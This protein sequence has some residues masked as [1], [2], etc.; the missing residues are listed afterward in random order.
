MTNDEA[1]AVREFEF[2]LSEEAYNG[3]QEQLEFVAR[4]VHEEETV[5]YTIDSNGVCIPVSKKVK[6]TRDPK[7]VLQ[8][9]IIVDTLTGG[10][11]GVAKNPNLLGN[12]G[13]NQNLR[14][15]K[16]LPT[17]LDDSIVSNK[18]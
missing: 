3:V 14:R 11:L 4:G 9:L 5:S 2:E 7:L 1:I 16:M 6:I 10:R 15:K 12:T 17:I 18:S 8:S 13:S